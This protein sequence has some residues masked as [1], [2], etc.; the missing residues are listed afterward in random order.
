MPENRDVHICEAANTTVECSNEK[1]VLRQ[2]D[3]EASPRQVLLEV[4]DLE[5]TYGSPRKPVKAV[6]RANYAI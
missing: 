5:V 1:T 3:G 4:K 6:K 2:Q